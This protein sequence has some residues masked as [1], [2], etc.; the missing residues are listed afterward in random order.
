MTKYYFWSG[1]S[2]DTKDTTQ[3]GIGALALETDTGDEYQ[4]TGSSWQKTGDA[5]SAHIR[6]KA[7]DASPPVYGSSLHTHVVGT[8]AT[9][10]TF[11][12]GDTFI[13]DMRAFGKATFVLMSAAAVMS[14]GA[15]V[16]WSH[17]GGA[18]THSSTELWAAQTGDRGAAMT[19]LDNFAHIAITR[20]ATSEAVYGYI[21]GRELA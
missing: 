11:T 14:H 4:W 5:G 3:V 13:V 9:K 12:S 20:D 6:I 10:V 8:P 15:T 7:D 19:I 2:S 17:D 18:E 21:T 1:L 16:T